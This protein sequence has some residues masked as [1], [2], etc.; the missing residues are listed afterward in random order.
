MS[1]I[2][3]AAGKLENARVGLGVDATRG[4]GLLSDVDNEVRS[5]SDVYAT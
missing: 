1:K 2:R 5:N 3:V 4:K